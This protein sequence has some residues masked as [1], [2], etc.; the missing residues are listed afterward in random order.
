MVADGIFE[1]LDAAPGQLELKVC[2][3]RGARMALL[4]FRVD[5]LDDELLSDLERWHARKNPTHLTLA[6]SSDQTS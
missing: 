2:D 3:A 1:E 6:E 4:Q 5:A